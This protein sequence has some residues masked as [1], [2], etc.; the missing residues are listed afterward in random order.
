[1]TDTEIRLVAGGL[2][3]DIGKLVYRQGV[4]QRAHGESG[5]DFLKNKAGLAGED[6]RQMLEAVRYHHASALEHAQVERDSLAYVIYAADQIAS[7]ADRREG[8]QREAALDIHMP[9][10]SIFNRLNGNQ[11][12]CSYASGTLYMA[13]H[14]R[15]PE[16][17]NQRLEPEFYQKILAD[18]QESTANLRW[19]KE[20]INSLLS[21]LEASLSYVPASARKDGNE[22]ISLYDHLK[23][24]AAVASCIYQYLHETETKDYK[25]RLFENTRDF[26]KED[27]FLLYSMDVS[28]IQDFIYT[29]ISK[30]A[31]KTLRARSFYL[32]IMM[33]HMIDGFL[34]E[35]HLT[36]ANLLYSGGGHCYL[37]LPNT[38]TAAQAADQYMDMLNGWLMETFQ[39]SLYVASG[40]APCSAN[41]LKNEPQGS[42]AELFMQV[43]SKISEKKS[44]RYT[45][46]E[47]RMLN[48]KIKEDHTRECSVCKR[49][50]KVNA[51]GICPVCQAIEKFSKNIL[52]DDFFIVTK[53][54]TVGALPLPGGCFLTADSRDSWQKHGIS[55]D[56]FVR[57]YSKNRMAVGADA[58]TKLWVGDYTT[59]KTFEEYAAQAEGI[60]RIGILRADVDNLGQAFVAGFDQP[61]NQ[62]RY[63]TL[64]RTAALS[65]QLS[66]FFKLY[67]NQ[68]LAEPDYSFNGMQTHPRNA[69]ICYS[70]GDDLFL[71]G[72]WNEVI[73]LAVDIRRQ[74]AKYTQNTLTLSA[75]IGI[76]PHSYPISAAAGETGVLE[77]CAKRLPGKN[78]VTI[79]RDGQEHMVMDAFG[80][81]VAVSDGTYHWQEFEQGVLGEKY[82]VLYDFFTTTNERGKNFLYHLLQLI[83][84]QNEKINFARYVYLL[85]RLEPERNAPPEQVQAYQDFSSKMYAWIK[86]ETDCLQLKT[87]I[88]LYAYMTRE[89]EETGWR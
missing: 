37:L 89:K 71:V 51:E 86:N 13:E 53:K 5:Y 63:V 46:A 49:I 3:H 57:A 55:E 30:N 52:Y 40:S 42:Y 32:E 87:A 36:R 12:K 20:G 75:G 74:F 54:K 8:S 21:V 19:T 44:K 23:M 82:R 1:M 78:A 68:I 2:L 66:L 11:G 79:C 27:A 62:D 64:S 22:D 60:G 38:E 25:N 26:N 58:A 69:T 61:G 80:K 48:A 24:T 72:A 73:A 85:S 59:G 17:E 50:G 16:A 29:I 35:L 56:G 88:H 31:L 47:L 77:D 18:I 67:I 39:I 10:Q 43:G 84:S 65:R 70:G 14:V 28:G 41:T 81:N 45:P 4:D 83:R 33:E 6:S 34:E 7:A 9:L 15:Y 76:Y